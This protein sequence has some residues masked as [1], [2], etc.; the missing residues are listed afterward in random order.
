[1]SDFLE[2]HGA[3]VILAGILVMGFAA[4]VAIGVARHVEADKLFAWVSGFTMGAFS[5]L[6]VALKVS[7]PQPPEPPTPP[8]ETPVTK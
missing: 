2:R 8:T 7:A 3:V 6:T 1:M 5:G 4:T